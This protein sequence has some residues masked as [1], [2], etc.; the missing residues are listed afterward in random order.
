VRGGM[1]SITSAMA[2][3]ARSRG[4]EIR[5]SSKVV[6]ILVRAGRAAGVVLAGGEEI[7]ARTVVSCA[8]PRR[9]FLEMLEPG[10]LSDEFVQA[11]RRYRS[12]GTSLKINLALD[13]LPDFRVFPGAQAGPQH[14]ATIHICPG[15]EYLERAW[16]DA[17][18]G[19]PSREP[20]IEMTIPTTY[21]PSLA[22]RGKHIMGIF[23]QYAPYT[24][25]RGNWDELRERYADQVIDIIAEYAPN[26][27]SL[28]LHRQVLTP[29]DLER[30]YGMTGGNIFHGAMSLDQMFFFRPV[31]G[32]ARYRTPIPNLYYAGSA[33]HPGGAI[34]G[35]PG[36]ISA[37]LI[38]RDLGLELWWKPWDARAAL[39]A[40]PQAA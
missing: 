10:H 34:S 21:D 31:A 3:S 33:A 4:A 15:M 14:R 16:D 36:Y 38:A 6:R 17:K 9:T 18:Y 32:W 20:L 13:G 29:L 12:E 28:I 39:A 37:G 35:G 25:S 11:I 26:I 22:P 1:G 8:D 19:Q 7:P 40:L 2:D 27:R 30:I 23:L 24:L 5:C